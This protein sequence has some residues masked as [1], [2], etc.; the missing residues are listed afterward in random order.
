MII[1]TPAT[2]AIHDAAAIPENPVFDARY[3]KYVTIIPGIHI[4]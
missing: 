1:I 2:E 4:Q 3:S